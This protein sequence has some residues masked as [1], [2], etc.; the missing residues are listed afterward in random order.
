MDLTDSVIGFVCSISHFLT[1]YVI[2]HR[3]IL[4]NVFIPLVTDIEY[5]NVEYKSYDKLNVD[6]EGRPLSVDTKPQKSVSYGNIP[7]YSRTAS[8]VS[9][10]HD[11][12]ILSENKYTNLI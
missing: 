9:S 6:S 1:M 4:Y 10:S 11:Y 7:H 8:T 3:C 2:V 12:H 5:A